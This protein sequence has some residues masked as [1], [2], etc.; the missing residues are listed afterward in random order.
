MKLFLGR[1][2]VATAMAVG[3]W[4]CWISPEYALIAFLSLGLAEHDFGK[5]NQKFDAYNVVVFAVV[6]LKQTT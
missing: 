5:S 4:L 6:I 3:L 2:A 1:C